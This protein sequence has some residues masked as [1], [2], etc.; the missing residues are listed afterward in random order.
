MKKIKKVFIVLIL[1]LLSGCTIKSEVVMENDGRIKENVYFEVLTDGRSEKEFELYSKNVLD[2]YNEALG[3]KGYQ[4]EVSY[5]KNNSEILVYN[6][7]DNICEYFENTVFSQYIYNHISCTQTDDYYEIKNETEHIDYCS[8]C[9]Y[10]PSLDNVIYSITLPIKAEDSN[11]DKEKNNTYTWEYNK[12]TS[13]DKQIYLKISKS[14]LE[15]NKLKYE[16]NKRKKTLINKFLSV[17]V[18][19]IIVVLLIFL[20]KKI[21]N[22]YKLNKLKY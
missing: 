20:V 11:A 18:I 5:R 13:K 7:F 12:N 3:V 6:Q 17:I 10:W 2:I 21:Y 22:K 14:S 9:T 19:S 8:D 4:T 15:D 16:S 1:L